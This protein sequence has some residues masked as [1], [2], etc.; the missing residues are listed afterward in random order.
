MAAAASDEDALE[1]VD[2]R[3][4][5]A[6]G[7]VIGLTECTV[8]YPLDLLKT[9]Q[10]F[11]TRPTHAPGLA[12]A[13]TTAPHASAPH[14]VARI[15][16]QT[17]VGQLYALGRQHGWRTLYRG[18]SWQAVG[19]VPCD[20]AHYFLYTAC[21]RYLLQ[22]E[23]GRTSPTAAF[24]AAG[25]VAGAVGVAA[26]VPVDIITQRL[27]VLDMQQGGGTGG[28]GTTATAATR[29]ATTSGWAIGRRILAT[30]GV[31]GLFRGL[32]MVLAIHVPGSAIWWA[33]SEQ[34]KTLFAW[35][36]GRDRSS[37]WVH[38]SA[39][40]LSGAVTTVAINPL[41][42][43]KTRIQAS[44]ARLPLRTH[45]RRLRAEEGLWTGLTKGLQP[46]LLSNVPRS[47][48]AFVLYEFTVW[49]SGR[50][51]PVGERFFQ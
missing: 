45:F 22:T 14:P 25:V 27:Q 34:S 47:S 9:R 1:R 19:A 17:A 35:L 2:R 6:V 24:T 43:L 15:G 7:W 5:F 16:S 30:E 51:W 40:A 29:P 8:F 38:A 48:F 26:V 36:L 50:P 10:Q 33:V 21:K 12:A 23:L 39:G 46:R 37:P 11:D 49:A 28:G 20:V 41:D 3:K 32:G 4:F 31:P 42:V 18:F 13:T 44:D